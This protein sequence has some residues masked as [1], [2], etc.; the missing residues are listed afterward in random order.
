MIPQDENILKKEKSVTLEALTVG[1]RLKL[2]RMLALKTRRA[3]QVTVLF[4]P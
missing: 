3:T 2:K 1:L 4:F